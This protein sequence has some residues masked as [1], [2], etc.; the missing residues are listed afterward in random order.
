MKEPT[1]AQ[2][3]AMVAALTRALVLNQ[4]RAKQVR[5][6]HMTWD[7]RQATLEQLAAD[8]ETLHNLRQRIQEAK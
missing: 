7:K 1:A 4:L 6:R 2:V 5:E 3:H 8:Y